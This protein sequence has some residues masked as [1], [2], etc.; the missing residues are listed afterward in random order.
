M[1]TLWQ[2]LRYSMR[3]LMKDPGFTLIATLTLALGI[4]ANTAI[5]SV[6]NAV[7]LRPLPYAEPERLLAVGSAPQRSPGVRQAVSYPDF[8]DW[9]ERNRTLEAIAVYHSATLTLTEAGAPA[10]LHG[11]VASAEL[12]D[13]LGARPQLGRVFT[14][15]EERGGARYAAIISHGLWRQRFDSDPHIIGRALTLEHKPFEIIGVMPPGFQFPIQAEPVEIWV[16]PAL[17]FEAP[18]EPGKQPVTE[19][20]GYRYLDAVARLK[21][22]VTLAQAQ[23]E[24]AGVAAALAKE[25]PDNNTGNGIILIPLLRDL[26][27]DYRQALAVVF[28]AVACVLLIACVNLAN[29]LLARASARQRELAVRSALGAGRAR[30]MRQLLTESMLLALIG[31]WCGLLLA[32]W[33]QES[34][35]R[36]LPEDLPRLS[37]IALNR[38]TFGFSFVVSLMTGVIFGLAPAWQATR[39]DLNEVLKDGLRGAS[40]GAGRAWLRSALVVAEVALALMLLIGASLLAQTFAQLKRA[41]LGFDERNVLTAS[42]SFSETAY[43]KPEQKIAFIQQALERV[44][45]LPGVA[46][47]SAVL[48]LPLSGDGVGGSFEF[49][50]RPAQRGDEPTTQ[51]RWVSLDYYRTMK[52]SVLAGRDFTARDDLKTTPVAIVNRAFVKKYFPNENPLGKQMSLPMGVRADSTVFQIVGVVS[53]VKHWKELGRPAEPEL[54]LPYAQL[55]FINQMSLVVRAAGAPAALADDVARAVHTLDGEAVLSDVK[56]LEQYLG[57]AVSQP[58]FSALL[59]SLFALLAL[60]LGAVG[61]YGMV[62]YSVAQR[63][64]EIG[65]RLAL[66]APRGAVLRLV[67]R[68]GISLTLLGVT[69]GL[70]ASYAL[71]R[72]LKSLLYGV[73]PTDPLTFAAIA[74]LLTFVALLA[75]W[76]PAWRATKVDPLIAI[77]CE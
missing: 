22:G 35:L 54:Y 69:L 38:Q 32:W 28:A 26:T 24:M 61:L 20:R 47:A 18:V 13:V 62:A 30:I 51:M 40:A 52:M 60:L 46:S 64:R 12:F 43:A 42:L 58:R 77:R 49:V 76:I 36:F 37:E 1:R 14:R 70:L 44:R 56:T 73:T 63:T 71:T 9:R 17:D 65:I 27:G 23:A 15:P 16:T 11:Q 3:M 55:P 48:P 21:P 72:L 34:L 31:G 66:G 8:V 19:R 50:G 29:L 53:D 6:V 57:N 4:G 74:L 45:A 75:C 7:L 59:F 41:P 33:G 67:M 25:Y 10:H 5:F 39:I 68:Q 2:D